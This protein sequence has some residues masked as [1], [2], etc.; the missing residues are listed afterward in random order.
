MTISIVI[1]E[2]RHD[3]DEVAVAERN[4]LVTDGL[5]VLTRIEDRPSCL[6][7]LSA[8]RCPR[9]PC[10][11]PE[12]RGVFWRAA[13]CPLIGEYQ[14]VPDRI[15][16]IWVVLVRGDGLLVIENRGVRVPLQSHWVAPL[17]T[18]VG[19]GGLAH[20]NRIVE[21]LGVVEGKRNL[22]RVSV[23]AK[24][25]PRIR[26]TLIERIA[27]ALREIRQLGLR[28]DIEARRAVGRDAC[29]EPAGAAGLV[30]ILLIDADEVRAIGVLGAGRVDVQP[31]LN[32]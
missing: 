16:I 21:I 23:G 32:L 31:W 19:G 18:G 1:L 28:K 2:H 5:I 29:S 4:D 6:P 27:G 24:A 30:S 22:V 12:C 14:P 3:I 20:Q 17:P 15:D 7:G 9:E 8:V 25:D 10:R 13:T 26:C 11:S